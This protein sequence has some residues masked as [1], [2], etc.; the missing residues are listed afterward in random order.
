MGGGQRLDLSPPRRQVQK[1]EN[2]TSEVLH[3]VGAGL[4]GQPTAN[5][6]K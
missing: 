1:L 5:L 2:L 4:N 3:L 6:G